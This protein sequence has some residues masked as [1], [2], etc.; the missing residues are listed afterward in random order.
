[1]TPS[2]YQDPT[3]TLLML[4]EKLS[5]PATLEE[6]LS[7]ATDAA[8]ELLPGDH[9]SVRV[10]DGAGEQ[11]LASARSG[12]GVKHSSIA[13]RRGEGIAGWAL[14]QARA[15]LVTDTRDDPRFI[16]S[17]K[18][19]FEVRSMVAAPLL[20]SGRAIAVLCVSSAK[21]GA[22]GP[23]Q[24]MT[25]RLLAGICVP[26]LEQ[27]RLE[28]LAVTDD[29]THAYNGRYWAPRLQQELALA[30][31]NGQCVSVAMLD[32]DHFKGVNDTHGHANGDRVLR[33]L[34]D[35][36]REKIR[37]SDILVRYGGEE[38][39]LL[40]PSTQRAQAQALAER[41]RQAVCGTPFP[42]A[43]GVNVTQTVSIG[44]ALWDGRETAEELVHRADLAMYEAKRGGRNRVA[45]DGA[46]ET[47]AVEL[48]TALAAPRRS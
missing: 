22:F 36:V 27:A 30:G 24:V 34:A 25:A 23:S 35:R 1:M 32:L 5:Q 7:A 26:A 41:I 9:A 48:A 8:L 16:A 18:Q 2:M 12:A 6:L 42:I 37:R 47:V 14:E 17:G 29:L 10:V 21:P 46:A 15:V 3:P 45:G 40:L 39:V 43:G 33:T 13:L 11:L 31:R 44:V 20:R 19:G 38:F 4:T 28:R